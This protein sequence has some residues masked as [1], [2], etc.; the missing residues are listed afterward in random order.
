MSSKAIS[1]SIK[2]Q[3]ASSGDIEG[4]ARSLP[5]GAADGVLNNADIIKCEEANDAA[6]V[7]AN[8]CCGE[9]LA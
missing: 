3:A 2:Y 9:A 5:N 6:T 7:K 1:T 4:A 8:F